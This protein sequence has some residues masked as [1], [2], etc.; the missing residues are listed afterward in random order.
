MPGCLQGAGKL[1]KTVPAL[2]EQ[3][4]KDKEERDNKTHNTLYNIIDGRVWRMAPQRPVPFKLRFLS[5]VVGVSQPKG[6]ED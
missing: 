2:K 3:R 6:G 1:T 5:R 4:D